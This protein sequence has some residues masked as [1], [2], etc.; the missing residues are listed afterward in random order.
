MK[1][2][3][4]EKLHCSTLIPLAIVFALRG[5]VRQRIKKLTSQIR[6]ILFLLCSFV[7]NFAQ[8][9]QCIAQS[10]P[11]CR[12]TAFHITLTK[13]SRT[14]SSI[15]HPSSIFMS[16]NVNIEAVPLTLS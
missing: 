6:V 7:E 14:A 13:V 9:H 2:K 16:F 12:V 4:A 11:D 3:V 8:I 15:Q 1:A 5:D 10:S